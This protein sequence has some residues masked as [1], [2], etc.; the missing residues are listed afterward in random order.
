MAQSGLV[1]LTIPLAQLQMLLGLIG[2]ISL[3]TG[4]GWLVSGNGRQPSLTGRLRWLLFG[5]AGSLVLY[6]YF[7]FG[8]PG[9]G[10]LAT[11]GGW[12]ALAVTGLGGVAGLIGYG[13]TR[14]KR[15]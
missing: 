3:T 5:L 8:L 12:G 11:W 15:E 10:W 9:A 13:L 7:I 2:G 1:A 14:I 4:V 6:N